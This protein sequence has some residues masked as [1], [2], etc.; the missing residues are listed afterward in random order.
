M[1]YV[2][3]SRKLSEDLGAH[4]DAYRMLGRM[5]GHLEGKPADQNPARE[6]FLMFL[7]ARLA[8]FDPEG[9]P[10]IMPGEA[11]E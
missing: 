3:L 11:A 2:G 1:D 5:I 9:R 6:E 10:F 8:D 4:D 7:R